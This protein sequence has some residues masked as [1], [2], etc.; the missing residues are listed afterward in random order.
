MLDHGL[1]LLE[2]LIEFFEEI[3]PRLIR[4][5]AIDSKSFRH[6]VMEFFHINRDSKH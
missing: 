4:Y 3:E 1:I 2:M 5:P 6:S